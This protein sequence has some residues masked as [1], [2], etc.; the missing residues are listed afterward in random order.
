MP[1]NENDLN[2]G[3]KQASKQIARSKALTH[4]VELLTTRREHCAIVPRDYRQSG[5]KNVR[6]FPAFR[7]H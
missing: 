4:A 5:F 1:Q 6:S 3:Y 7:L 2:A